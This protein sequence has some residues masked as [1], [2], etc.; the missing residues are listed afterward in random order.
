MRW[1][2]FGKRRHKEVSDSP[3]IKGAR[4]WLQDLREICE[5]NYE[6][7][8]AGQSLV[9]EIQV[10]WTDANRR[11]D[12]DDSLKQGLDRRAFRLLRADAEEWLGWLDNEEFW[13]PG[14]KGGFDN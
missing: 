1:W 10:E 4:M 14:W 7:P 2:P 11:G 6:N 13:K 8:S 9:R 12:L 5:R 3:H